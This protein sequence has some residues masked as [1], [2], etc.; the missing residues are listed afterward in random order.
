MSDERAARANQIHS[1]HLNVF[2]SSTSP[3]KN[4][5]KKIMLLL[6]CRVPLSATLQDGGNGGVTSPESRRLEGLEGGVGDGG[7]A[8]RGARHSGDIIEAA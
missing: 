3:Q 8:Q 2:V 1:F 4:K 6:F 7:E 5:L